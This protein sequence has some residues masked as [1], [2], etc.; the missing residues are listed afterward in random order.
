MVLLAGDGDT[1]HVFDD[2]APYLAAGFRVFGITRR[3]FG[4]S[5]Q[6][7]QG[8]TLPRLAEDVAAVIDRLKLGR[9]DLIGHSIA[10]DEMIQC[11]L[12]YPEKV[13]KLVYLDAAYDRVESERLE[14]KFPPV[15]PLP[16]VFNEAGPPEQVRLAVAVTEALLPQSEIS[17]TRVFGPNGQYE[18]PVTPDWIERDIA[19]MVERPSYASI[20]TPML[21]IYA[22]PRNPSQQFASYGVSDATRRTALE[23]IFSLWKQFQRRQIAA[24]RMAAPSAKID[25]IDGASHYVFISNEDQVI[26]DILQFL[27]STT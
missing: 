14:A 27:Q 22:N 6:P 13:N 10:G 3:G 1:A 2:F 12:T 9:V 16:S 19:K 26:R 8:Y 11:A 17:A 5:S 20:H 4:A 7:E 21:A 23:Q 25:V 24:F 18:R 15:S